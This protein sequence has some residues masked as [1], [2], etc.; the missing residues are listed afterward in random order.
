[1]SKPKPRESITIGAR[2][3]AD[4][5]ADVIEFIQRMNAGK[6]ST[7]EIIIAAL[8]MLAKNEPVTPDQ[9]TAELQ[10]LVLDMRGFVEKLKHARIESND[11]SAPAGSGETD[12]SPT[13]IESLAR[14][15][16]SGM[17]Q[18]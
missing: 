15:V 18:E 17:G 4:S 1:M 10:Q 8:R 6:K 14:R 13:M 9:L 2:L 7:Q 3:Y 5:D 12:I 11:T 16:S